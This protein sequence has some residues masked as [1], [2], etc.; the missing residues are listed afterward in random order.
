MAD[1][2]N[3]KF[4]DLVV[5][6]EKI[7]TEKL[8]LGGVIYKNRNLLPSLIITEDNFEKAIYDLKMVQKICNQFS[9]DIVRLHADLFCYYGFNDNPEKHQTS[10]IYA[11]LNE[12]AVPIVAKLGIS[13]ENAEEVEKKVN[14]EVIQKKKSTIYGDEYCFI[15][16]I[17]NEIFPIY[18]GLVSL[19]LGRVYF[20]ENYLTVITERMN[21][22]MHPSYEA[23]R[24]SFK[25]VEILRMFS[26][27]LDSVTV[28]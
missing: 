14:A 9:E 22:L 17:L 28:H 3:K 8:R 25:V 27:N 26:N 15:A 20:N 13:K 5:E 10:P 2:M 11:I 23:L 16:I 24:K 1:I 21:F 18:S 19:L 4:E 6:K 12:M 7:E